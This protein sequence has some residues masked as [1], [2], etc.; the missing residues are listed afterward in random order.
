M[1]ES[2]LKGRDSRAGIE[3]RHR[4]NDDRDVVNIPV[5]R[6]MKRISVG[7]CILSFSVGLAFAPKAAA[8]TVTIVVSPTTD[9]S[10][11]VWN[12]EY[13]VW[14]WNGPE[15]QGDYQG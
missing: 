15:F 11:W 5:K 10:Y 3:N 4:S 13:Q 2:I 8:Q 1:S 7:L 12:D 14:V 6:I 9:D